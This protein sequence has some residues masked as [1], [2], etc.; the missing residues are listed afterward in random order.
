MTR[1]ASGPE[2]EPDPADAGGAPSWRRLVPSRG[3]DEEGGV[4]LAL[5]IDVRVAAGRPR[6]RWSAAPTRPAIAA[7]ARRADTAFEVRVRPLQRST[8]TGAWI[9]GDASWER[10]RFPTGGLD[11]DQAR[12][13]VELRRMAHDPLG[14]GEYL[15]DREWL[16]LD[17][18]GSA[19]LG[20]HLR[21]AA[22]LGIAFVPASGALRIAGADPDTRIALRIAGAEGGGLRLDTVVREGGEEWPAGLARALGRAGVFRV[23]PGGGGA[24]DESVALRL[25]LGELSD[26]LRQ[27]LVGREPVVI[28][29]DDL[30]A[31]AREG[32]PALRAGGGIEVDDDVRARLEDGARD[33]R[34]EIV[35]RHRSGDVAAYEWV[36]PEAPS[37][38]NPDPGADDGAGQAIEDVLGADIAR[39]WR[40]ASDLPL[41]AEAVLRGGDAAAF[42]DRVLPALRAVPTVRVREHGRARTYEA[43]EGDPR[44]V[45]R[46]AATSA[47][48]GTG[49]TDWFD[50]AVIVEIEGRRIPLAALI[51]GIAARKKRLLLADGAYFSLTHP[52][53][54]RLRDLLDE[55]RELDEWETGARVSRY[56]VTWFEDFEDV[57]EFAEPARAWRDA[58]RGLQERADGADDGARLAP[59]VPQPEGFRGELRAYQRA[60]LDWL[61]LLW[62]LRLGGILADDMGLGK[63][64]Q[65][66]ALIAH[67]RARGE[68]APFLVV[69]PTSVLTA[70]REEAARFVP[71]LPL[72]VLDRGADSA[73]ARRRG[74]LRQ[75]IGDAAIVVVPYAVVRLDAERL[76]AHTWA[77]VIL[78][79]AQVVKNPRTGVHRAIAAIPA[80]WRLAITGTPME[81]ALSD[82]WALLSLTAPGVFPSWRAFR[83]HYVGPIE[84]GKV[85][86]NEEGGPARAERLALLRRRIRPFVL[87]RTKEQV[88]PELPA[89]QEQELHV[90]LSPAHRAHYTRTLA[91]E[92]QKVLGL[93]EDLDRN[94]FIVFR[95]LTLLRMLA[96]DPALVGVEVADDADDDV[97]QGAEDAATTVPTPARPGEGGAKLEALLERLVEIVAEGH[98]VLVFSQFTSYLAI[99]RR[100]LDAAG[101]AHEYLD[102]A[103]RERGR[104]LARFREG[105][106]PVF[107]ISLK[108]GGVG[109]TI[110]EADY[111]F[112]LDPWWNPAAEQQ[113]IDRTHRIGQTREVMVYRL[114]A[115]DTIEEKVRALQRRKARLFEA[116]F[117]DGG[118]AFARAMTTDDVRF[119]LG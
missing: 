62:E 107:L 34:R 36:P 23:D 73:A 82:L 70:W 104:V 43:L 81:N 98:R 6:S 90:E 50:L 4:P 37:A 64:A 22:G 35:V 20:P 102:G 89:R 2:R 39:A 74:T 71:D 53:L 99:V 112:L 68:R 66:L 84:R 51:A 95:S 44:I 24:G 85:P 60:G 92:R 80:P 58:A 1:D 7:D 67:A 15:A 97:G 55:A 72:V 119:L 41:A 106:A 54:E 26:S 42:V 118:E 12:W 79:E 27:L 56:R 18:L 11:R 101:I 28:P 52:A 115:S 21:A 9:Q 8:A 13:F 78:D 59:R 76:A 103:T 91:R 10:L 17:T 30:A 32:Y 108:A 109:L 3:A 100:R 117:D 63:T 77:G 48:A 31:F 40:R 114:I 94:R 61:A 19:L 88:A 16:R 93:L 113:A 45:L 57:A 87:R 5:A 46:Q 69:A 111:V 110:T 14:T 105:D 83:Q 86:E 38:A 75:R 33:T 96:L 65:T 49:P 25:A 29:S 116:V 47:P